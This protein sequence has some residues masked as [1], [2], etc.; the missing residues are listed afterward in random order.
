MVERFRCA[1]CQGVFEKTWSDAEALMESR[2]MFGY[3]EP[4]EIA[5]V[6]D[7]CFM[8]IYTVG[9]SRRPTLVRGAALEDE[10]DR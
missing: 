1:L 8:D 5:T 10:G 2:R 6:C 7:T 3:L 9:V 4:D